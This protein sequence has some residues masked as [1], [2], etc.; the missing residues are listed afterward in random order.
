M[1]TNTKQ[2]RNGHQY[3]K[4]CTVNSCSDTMLEHNSTF[5][6]IM[7]FA[8]YYIQLMFMICKSY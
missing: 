2:Y 8:R 4:I 1:I 3:P 5:K 7:L 6:I